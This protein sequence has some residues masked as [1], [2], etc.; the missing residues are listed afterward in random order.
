MNIFYM[1]NAATLKRN[2][3]I[4]HNGWPAAERS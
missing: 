4:Q 3:K 2:V 1:M